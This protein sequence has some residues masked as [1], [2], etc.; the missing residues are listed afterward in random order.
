MAL[1]IILSV[2]NGLDSLIKSFY[3]TIDPD[4]K[5]TIAEGKVFSM[6]E[7]K[8]KNLIELKEIAYYTEVLEENA[9]IEYEKRQDLAKIKGVSDDFHNTSGIYLW[10]CP[11][12]RSAG[13]RARRCTRSRS[14]TPR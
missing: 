13:S 4:F 5:V 8:I 1:I 6:S 7:E 9:L 14:T 2:F 10:P 3:S 11:S 12:G